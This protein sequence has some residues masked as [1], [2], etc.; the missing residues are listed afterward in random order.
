M[1][2]KTIR[3]RN[4][5]EK[6][7][8][9]SYKNN[10]LELGFSLIELLFIITLST[11]LL[12]LAFPV[13]NHLILDLRLFILTDR[14]CSTLNYAR[15]EA[16]RRQTV[17]TICKS[18]DVK[19]CSGNWKKGWIVLKNKNSTSSHEN[20]NLLRVFPALNYWEFLEWHGFHSDNYVQLFPDGSIQNGHFI[21]CVNVLSKKMIS[22]IKISST[23]RIRI[24]SENNKN[25]HCNG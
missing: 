15:S 14:V 23:G 7:V 10:F 13:Y 11:I 18:K 4:Y 5:R 25:Q 21:L 3:S 8:I 6:W 22:I 24:E 12:T 1:Y 19:S 20:G 2:K 16:I 17:I 9:S